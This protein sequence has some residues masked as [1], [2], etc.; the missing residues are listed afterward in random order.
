MLCPV[1]SDEPH[2]AVIMLS[3]QHYTSG[4]I[5]IVQMQK[6]RFVKLSKSPWISSVKNALE[7]A[8]ELESEAKSLFQNPNLGK[9]FVDSVDSAPPPALWTLCPIKDR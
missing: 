8:L 5:S 4:C 7:L 1:Y 9:G 3:Q 2:V 6:L